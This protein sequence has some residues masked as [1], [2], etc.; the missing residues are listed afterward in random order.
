MAHKTEIKQFIVSSF[1]PDVVPEDI[2]DDFDLLETGTVDSLGLLSL[3]SWLEQRYGLSVS[4]VDI[5]PMDFRSVAAMDAFVRE[6]A[7]SP[8]S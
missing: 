1:A 8:A 4:D 5:S 2:A 6:H 3:I 7:P